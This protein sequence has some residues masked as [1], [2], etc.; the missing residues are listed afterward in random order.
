MAIQ[1][2]PAVFDVKQA[3]AYIH[4]NADEV[5]RL[6]KVGELTGWR[7]LGT[8]GDWRLSRATCDEW[9]ALQVERGRLELAQ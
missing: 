1:I 8:R 9:I 5:R 3:A 6:L 2:E 7:T 4:V